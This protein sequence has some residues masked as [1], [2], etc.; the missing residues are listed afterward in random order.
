M[1]CAAF[2]PAGPLVASALGFAD[3]HARALGQDGWAGL[4]PGT[5]LSAAVTGM[6]VLAVAL[7]G[8]RMMLTGRVALADV[9]GL[10]LRLGV[11]LALVGQ[12]PAWGALVYDTV[13]GAGDELAGAVLAPS[14]LGAEAT[15]TLAARVDGVAAAAVPVPGAAPM[16]QEAT[17]HLSGAVRMIE[18]SALVALLGPRLGAGVALALGPVA[19]V[20]LLFGGTRGLALG[21]A[22]VAVA[23]VVAQVA[24]AGALALELAVVEPQMTLLA[25]IS[26]D[27]A[28]PLIERIWLIGAGF[29]GVMV[30][31]L[32]GIVLA[33]AAWRWPVMAWRH[34]S[35]AAQADVR[36]GARGPVVVAQLSP[37]QTTQGDNR[38]RHLADHLR[39]MSAHDARNAA[40]AVGGG[41]LVPM[42]LMRQT[43]PARAPTPSRAPDATARRTTK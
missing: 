3:C 14:G 39:H 21:W 19:T 38:A 34:A 42:R 20:M 1:G 35:V 24:L 37:Q 41:A 5:S 15:G 30:L 25:Q 28:A 2:D 18:M 27:Q 8:W 29:A 9:L 43:T 7:F 16:P 6:M 26:A 13:I 4:G 17:Q 12:W 31:V 11:V 32:G 23:S 10:V 40:P 22:R 36:T 33:M